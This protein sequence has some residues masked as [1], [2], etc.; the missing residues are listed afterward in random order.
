MSTITYNE[1][2]FKT[3]SLR[4][5]FATIRIYVDEKN[6]VKNEE[7]AEKLIREIVQRDISA[8]DVQELMIEGFVDAIKINPNNES[9]HCLI[10]ELCE[11]IASANNKKKSNTKNRR[12]S[13]K[14]EKA[15]NEKNNNNEKLK[16]VSKVKLKNKE[17]KKSSKKTNQTKM[18]QMKTIPVPEN[19]LPEE[20]TTE[21]KLFNSNLNEEFSVSPNTVRKSPEIKMESQRG[22]KSQ[23]RNNKRRIDTDHA[24]SNSSKVHRSNDDVRLTAPPPGTYLRSN[25][26]DHLDYGYEPNYSHG[27]SDQIMETGMSFNGE[28]QSESV[29]QVQ[30]PRVAIASPPESQKYYSMA[31][32][33]DVSHQNA[34]VPQ[35][36]RTFFY[37]RPPIRIPNTAIQTNAYRYPGYFNTQPTLQT[38]PYSQYCINNMNNG[39]SPA[40]YPSTGAP[41]AAGPMAS[42]PSQAGYRFQGQIFSGYDYPSTNFNQTPPTIRNNTTQMATNNAYISMTPAMMQPSPIRTNM[43]PNFMAGMNPPYNAGPTVAVKRHS[44]NGGFGGQPTVIKMVRR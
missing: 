43:A 39:A 19:Q 20:R 1:A 17:D 25:K 34:M 33:N 2:A 12:N 5:L 42:P 11:Q 15:N 35:R 7:I 40:M 29:S 23:S 32:N 3:A 31:M 13:L 44:Q 37:N 38:A 9:L 22:T 28:S 27:F 26:E 4:E 36:P 14:S 21:D 8:N 30:M 24:S 16:A 41:T 6:R 18:A 10:E